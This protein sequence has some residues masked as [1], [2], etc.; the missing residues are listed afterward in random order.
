MIARGKNAKEDPV[1][2]A[3]RTGLEQESSRGAAAQHTNRATSSG[4]E[5]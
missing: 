1:E 5:S 4:G 3:E 2:G